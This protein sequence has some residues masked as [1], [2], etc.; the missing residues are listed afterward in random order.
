MAW[1]LVK[2]RD[3]FTFA[4]TD[5]ILDTVSIHPYVMTFMEAIFDVKKYKVSK[6]QVLNIFIKWTI[7]CFRLKT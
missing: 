6:K 2:H 4:L 1:D 7:D 3:N 5:K